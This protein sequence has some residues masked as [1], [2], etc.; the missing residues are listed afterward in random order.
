[1]AKQQSVEEHSRKIS[2]LALRISYNIIQHYT[3]IQNRL[4]LTCQNSIDL[5][6]TLFCLR[7]EK[8]H[9][10][11]PRAYGQ[12]WVKLPRNGVYYE[13][14]YQH[15]Q[16]SSKIYGSKALSFDPQ[17]YPD[18]TKKHTL[19]GKYWNNPLAEFPPPSMSASRSPR[20]A[21]RR[22]KVAVTNFESHVSSAGHSAGHSANFSKFLHGKLV[23]E[24]WG[25]LKVAT[26]RYD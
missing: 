9:L 8:K 18:H 19:I 17:P 3:S 26:V 7:I 22:M 14:Y 25:K 13:F 5:F 11:E 1:M 2:E 10:A 15:L 12:V 21:G 6:E 16:T 24:H 4:D 20:S 23:S